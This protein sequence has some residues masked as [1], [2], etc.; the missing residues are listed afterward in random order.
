MRFLKRIILLAAMLL[1]G[2]GL[3]QGGNFTWTGSVSADWFNTNNWSPVGVPAS[4]DTI[5]FD[6]GTINL[7]APVTINGQ[8]NWSGGTLSGSAL[9]IAT[10]GVMNLS[11]GN[12]KF[13]LNVLTN[14][15]TVTWTSSGN[16]YV[17]NDNS[18]SR[19]AIYNLAGGLFDIQNDQS[20]ACACYGYEFFRNAGTVRKSAGTGTTTINVPFTNDGT[21][22]VESGILNFSTFSQTSGTLSLGISSS[23][24]YGRINF[25]NQLT[26]TGTLNAHLVFPYL[27]AVGNTFTLLTYPSR[28][29]SFGAFALDP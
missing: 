23:T 5:N 17:Y 3:V 13:L 11:G 26:M 6:T 8:F 27:P 12:N 20:L 21:V 29:G 24:V 22:D 14:A 1:L 10:N 2:S 16:L 15:G 4:S 19:G 7:T 25:N 9:T 28:T 18:S